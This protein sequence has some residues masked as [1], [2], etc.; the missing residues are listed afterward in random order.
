MNSVS[1]RDVE[2]Y[3]K[4]LNE[5]LNNPLDRWKDGKSQIGNIHICRQY[6]YISIH[7]ICNEGGGVRSLASGLTKREAYNWY[8]AALE[9]IDLFKSSLSFESVN[10]PISCPS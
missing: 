8:R 3:E 4:L 9:G 2:H 7:Q 6:G 10:R 5:A 1:L